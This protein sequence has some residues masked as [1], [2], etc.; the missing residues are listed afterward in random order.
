MDIIFLL[1]GLVVGAIA[2]WFGAAFKYKGEAIRSEEVSKNFQQKLEEQKTE[3][4][5]NRNRGTS[6]KIHNRV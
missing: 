4:E 6:K 1:I 2:A 5:V 3:I